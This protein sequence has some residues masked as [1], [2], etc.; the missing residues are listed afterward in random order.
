MLV[1]KI[2][3]MNTILMLTK[4]NKETINKTPGEPGVVV[5]TKTNDSSFS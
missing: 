4:L 3:I 2:T 1:N 5:E